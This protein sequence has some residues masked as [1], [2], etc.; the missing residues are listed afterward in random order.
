MRKIIE[1]LEENEIEYE[2]TFYSS[3]KHP[4]RIGNFE[5]PG[6]AVYFNSAFPESVR[7][8]EK[9][10]RFMESKHTYTVK[11]E[12]IFDGW[13]YHILTK[14]DKRRLD[15]RDAAIEEESAA[16]FREIGYAV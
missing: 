4:Y 10:K 5:V 9:F 15:A 3:Y 12:N 16:F 2:E 14:R 13:C 8:M 7:S 11:I 6:I 1:F